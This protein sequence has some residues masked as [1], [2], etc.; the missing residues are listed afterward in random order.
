MQ[1]V[2]LSCILLR[3]HHDSSSLIGSYPTGNTANR[4]EVS[5]PVTLLTVNSRCNLGLSL[6]K[7]QSVRKMECV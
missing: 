6:A 1:A 7:I 5:S 3:S 2:E 4:A